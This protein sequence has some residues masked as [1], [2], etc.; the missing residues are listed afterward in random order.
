MARAYADSARIALRG[1][2]PGDAR[3][4]A[5]STSLLG[6]ALAYL[7]RKTDAIREGRRGLELGPPS[8]NAFNGPYNQH[9]LARIYIMSGESDQALDQL[10]PLLELPYFLSPAWLRIDPTFEPLRDHPRF[11]RIVEGT[12]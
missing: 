8:A 4:R 11:R 7:G 5:N 9:Q 10:E 2:D 3:Q 6:T 12:A 1:A